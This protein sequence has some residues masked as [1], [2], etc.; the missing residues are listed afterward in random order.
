MK[1]AAS[2]VKAVVKP[3]LNKSD[4]I[5]KPN[6]INSTKKIASLDTALKSAKKPLAAGRKSGKAKVES[7]TA[8]KPKT[9]K[10]N[11]K[12]LFKVPRVENG[13]LKSAVPVKINKVVAKKTKQIVSKGK[14]VS[15]N[16][17]VKLVKP[18][19][20]AKSKS[21][22]VV[23]K[24]A[25]IKTRK[26]V[27]TKIKVSAP[28][29]K[30]APIKNQKQPQTL[31]KKVEKAKLPK[32]KPSSKAAEVLKVKRAAP[33]KK[34]L[35]A[36]KKAK[37][38]AVAP[39][40]K[41][42]AEKIRPS[43]SVKKTDIAAKKTKTLSAP[44]TGKAKSSNNVAVGRKAETKSA[45]TKQIAPIVEADLK[46][47]TVQL[48][49]S[50]TTGKIIETKSVASVSETNPKA[51]KIK[52]ANAAQNENVAE[53]K[54][55]TANLSEVK[56]VKNK[57]T[58]PIGTAVFRGRKE[59]YDFKVFSIKEEIENVPAIYIISRRKTDKY[60]R[61]HH[62]L[63]CIGQTDSISDEIKKHQKSKCV[64]KFDANVI[65]ILPEENEKKRLKIET[66]LRAAHTIP[67]IHV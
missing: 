20:T 5:I 44:K 11:S 59:R 12:T 63:V 53:N 2:N 24:P 19:Q 41:S 56:V 18:F 27:A 39:R 61:G 1:Y 64:K 65:S 28:I 54:I 52:S 15:K 33:I 9:Q 67:C 14:S 48:V 57:K 22:K 50:A 46:N 13:K 62:S 66:D 36:S 34:I 17:S 60:N 8:A 29:K 49:Y 45:K 51:R 38:I 58:K 4:K 3:K 47:K 31:I 6:K 26:A 42:K 23:L 21:P 40:I 32:S 25:K 10:I 37:N 7:V 16:Q 55:E 35:T 30:A 43:V